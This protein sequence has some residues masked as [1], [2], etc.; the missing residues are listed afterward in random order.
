MSVGESP[1]TNPGAPDGKPNPSD[2]GATGPDALGANSLEGGSTMPSLPPGAKSRGRPFAPGVSGNP[3]GRPRGSRNKAT[4][5]A[6]AVLEGE[7]EILARKLIDKAKE[8][9]ISALRFAL[10]RI[11]PPQ[12][13]RLVTVEIPEIKSAQDASK[14]AAAVVAA[15]AAGDISTGEAADFMGL[16]A[17]YVRLLEVGEI[18]ARLKAVEDATGISS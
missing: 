9:D 14:A 16:V 11:C 18:E 6:E 7:A 3:S 2:C 15:C 17:S 1:M 4:L 12:R 10:E 5:A 8:G 13:E